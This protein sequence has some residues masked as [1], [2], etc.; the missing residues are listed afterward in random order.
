MTLFIF[1]EKIRFDL[2]SFINHAI[3]YFYKYDL[4]ALIF[5]WYGMLKGLKYHLL[6]KSKDFFKKN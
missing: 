3:F 1:Y 4:L 6:N 2:L 5:I